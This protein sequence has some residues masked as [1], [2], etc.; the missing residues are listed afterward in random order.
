[1]NIVIRPL[2][3][4]IAFGAPLAFYVSIFV[5]L[6]LYKIGFKFN[7]VDVSEEED[8]APLVASVFTAV[9]GE[10]VIYLKMKWD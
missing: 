8:V 7:K 6:T 5:I 10:K 4:N 1:M 9:F 2:S 3:K